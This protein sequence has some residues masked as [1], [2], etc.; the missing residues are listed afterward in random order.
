MKVT[1]VTETVENRKTWNTAR[2]RLDHTGTRLGFAS[3][4]RTF[5]LIGSPNLL[6]MTKV[7]DCKTCQIYTVSKTCQG[8]TDSKTCHGFTD[9]KSCQG[10][11]DSKSCQG[12]KDSCTSNDARTLKLLLGSLILK[13]MY[14]PC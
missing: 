1:I 2:L 5:F 12:F 3:T 9:S 14:D 4:I 7:P 8:F 6:D 13:L 10:F 11:P